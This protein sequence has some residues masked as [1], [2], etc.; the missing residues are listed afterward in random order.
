MKMGYK[1]TIEFFSD[2]KKNI[3][4]KFA[5][6]WIEPGTTILSEVTQSQKY[7]LYVLLSVDPSSKSVNLNI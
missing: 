2:V 1:C 4:I 6:K 7:K 5:G 3:I